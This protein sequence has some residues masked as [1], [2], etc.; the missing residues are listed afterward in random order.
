MMITVFALFAFMQ[1]NAQDLKIGYA[2]TDSILVSLA[3]F[4]TQQTTLQTYSK[5]LQNQLKITLEKAQKEMGILQQKVQTGEMS[6]A[7]AEAEAYKKQLE[8]QKKEAEAQQLLAKKE[9]ALLEPLYEK[10]QK[11]IDEVA[12][13][14]GY[15]YIMSKRVFLYSV[16]TSD[17]TQ[18]VINKLKG[19]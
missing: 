14:E 19:L 13:E 9:A 15:T 7:E 16:E 12:K 3:E 5:Q 2:N 8:L 18:K 17:V 11:G 6:Q 4:K 10:V 1:A